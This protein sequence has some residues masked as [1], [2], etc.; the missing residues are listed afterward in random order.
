MGTAT[1][2]RASRSAATRT[3]NK[4]I[5]FPDGDDSLVEGASAVYYPVQE[6]RH[7]SDLT[8]AACGDADKTVLRTA[9]TLRR[10]DRVESLEQAR[11]GE[12]DAQGV[13]HA[14][15]EEDEIHL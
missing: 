4:R 2:S 6:R 15:G 8:M 9:N 7:S 13:N 5:V 1:F 10:S 12:I 14:D 11:D 3:L